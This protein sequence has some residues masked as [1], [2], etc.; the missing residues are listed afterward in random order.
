MRAIP[1]GGLPDFSFC[2]FTFAFVPAARPI[3]LLRSGFVEL[4]IVDGNVGL[5]LQN[6]DR[7][8]VS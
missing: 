7:Q 4:R 1:S 3:L 5:D 6:F 2:L 8:F